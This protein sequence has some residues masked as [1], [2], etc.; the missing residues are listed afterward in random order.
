MDARILMIG[1]GYWAC[2]AFHLAEYLYTPR[3]PVRAAACVVSTPDG[4]KRWEEYEDVVLDDRQFEDIGDRVER[5]LAVRRSRVGRAEVRLPSMH[6]PV[7]CAA[8]WM[9]MNRGR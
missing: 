3:P 1:V 4:G 7:D 6:E 2:T 5:D 9:S 8:E